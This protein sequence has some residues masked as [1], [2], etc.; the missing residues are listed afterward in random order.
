MAILSVLFSLFDDSAIKRADLRFSE[1]IGLPGDEYHDDESEVER[2]S[3]EGVDHRN[4]STGSLDKVTS[5]R[6][7]V[8]C[9]IV[10]AYL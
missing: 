10:H 1:S 8:Q 4:R 2:H 3:N 6:D 5:L 7:N 9:Q